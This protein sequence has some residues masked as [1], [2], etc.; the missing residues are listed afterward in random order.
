MKGTVRKGGPLLLL[1]LVGASLVIRV[2]KL[3]YASTH[4]LPIAMGR[5]PAGRR[6][7]PV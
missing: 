4:V 5:M 6:G 1:L 7:S 2:A 3:N